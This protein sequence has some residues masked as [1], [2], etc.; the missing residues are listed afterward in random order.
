MRQVLF[1]LPC[2]LFF[3]WFSGW[4]SPPLIGIL[5]IQGL[6]AMAEAMLVVRLSSLIP[7]FSDQE[8]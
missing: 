4:F 7:R 1:A 3:C 2:W 5:V 8:L 6:A